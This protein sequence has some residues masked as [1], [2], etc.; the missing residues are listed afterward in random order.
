M[1][2]FISKSLI[3]ELLKSCALTGEGGAGVSSV[4]FGV[5]GIGSKKNRVQERNYRV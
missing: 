5:N 1:E 3:R 2:T 4:G